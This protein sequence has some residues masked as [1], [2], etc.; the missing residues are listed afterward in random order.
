MDTKNVLV[1]LAGAAVAYFVIKQMEKKKADGVPAPPVNAPADP[2]MVACQA[3][4]AE[5]LKTV[6]IADLEGY[7][8][9]FMAD[10]MAAVPEAPETSGNIPEESVSAFTGFAG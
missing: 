2:K 10:C 1:F 3:Q 7:K 6:R 9:Q 4:L 8:A 5:A